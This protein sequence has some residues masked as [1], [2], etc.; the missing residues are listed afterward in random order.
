MTFN[1]GESKKELSINTV[2]DCVNEVT[3]TFGIELVVDLPN[4]NGT[5]ICTEVDSLLVNIID[6]D[7]E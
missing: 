4:V 7:S 6:I 1:P 3:E 5:N 2:D